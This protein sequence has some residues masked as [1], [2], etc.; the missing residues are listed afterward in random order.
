MLAP[1]VRLALPLD[2]LAGLSPLRYR[3]ETGPRVWPRWT[4]VLGRRPC[5]SYPPIQNNGLAGWTE[6]EAR[7]GHTA[8]RRAEIFAV[9]EIMRV[10]FEEIDCLAVTLNDLNLA[11]D[12]ISLKVDAYRDASVLF[13]ELR[14]TGQVYQRVG[15]FQHASHLRLRQAKDAI[16]HPGLVSPPFLQA[17]RRHESGYISNGVFA[18]APPARL[19]R[20]GVCLL[21]RIIRPTSSILD[22]VEV[23]AEPPKAF[24]KMQDLPR[25]PRQRCP[26]QYAH[27]DESHIIC[28]C[29]LVAPVGYGTM[30]N[31][32]AQEVKFHNS[33]FYDNARSKSAP[34]TLL[35]AK[36]SL[37]RARANLH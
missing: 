16:V 28:L 37:A 15:T 21:L 2:I 9:R 35:A 8:I 10:S 4:V 23:V 14:R 13:E 19:R 25:H 20:V 36:Y 31:Q 1:K 12:R 34:A 27:N 3:R 24:K 32:Y 5:L 33:F 11:H 22:V 18:V 30:G 26:S 7:Q 29:R 6:I 17:E